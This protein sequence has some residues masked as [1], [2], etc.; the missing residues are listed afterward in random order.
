MS[1]QGPS[2]YDRHGRL[3]SQQADEYPSY[4][5]EVVF[6]VLEELGIELIDGDH[7][8]WRRALCPMHEERGASFGIL[9]PE[10]GW[11]CRVGCGSS[12]D[13]AMLVHKT[14]GEPLLEV[15]R[16]LK[17]AIPKDPQTLMKMLQG[18]LS[19]KKVVGTLPLEPLLYDRGRVPKYMVNRGFTMETLHRWEVGYDQEFHC[20][21]VPVKVGGKLV[22]LVRRNLNP[23]GSK[24]LNTR[25]LTK[26]DFLFGLDHV[27]ADCKEITVV[28]GPLD[29][30]WLHQ[31]GIPAV[32]VLGSSISERQAELIRRR[33]WRVCLA[34]DNDKAGVAA[35]VDAAIKLGQLEVRAIKLPEGRKDVQECT[36][37]EL[38]FA[39]THAA[40]PWYIDL[41]V[42][43]RPTV[44]EQPDS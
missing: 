36:P 44:T 4:P 1:T 5:R 43:D 37:E 34:F 21:V 42:G 18:G 20:V 27:A 22:G 12:P 40:N 9:I 7:D 8:G 10:G 41:R 39:F 38:S 15:R 31:N 33:F 11:K 2:K 14:T 6:M 26:G 32:A 24:Y 25:G 30:M 19:S 3:R 29:C 23:G 16:R 13:L 28:E 35:G 17:L